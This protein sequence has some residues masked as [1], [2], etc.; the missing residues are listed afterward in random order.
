ME[1]GNDS[2]SRSGA[3]QEGRSGPGAADSQDM[4][5]V[6]SRPHPLSLPVSFSLSQKEIRDHV[7]C[8]GIV[9]DSYFSLFRAFPPEKI[10]E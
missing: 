1:N 8:I 5:D 2:Q 10:K 9:S 6:P 4:N 7:Y 3:A